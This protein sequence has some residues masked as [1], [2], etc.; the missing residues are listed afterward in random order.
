M[1]DGAIVLIGVSQGGVGGDDGPAGS[2][3]F[4]DVHQKVL[5]R[6]HSFGPCTTLGILLPSCQTLRWEASVGAQIAGCRE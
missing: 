3:P 2:T 5:R 4:S 1:K 6:N